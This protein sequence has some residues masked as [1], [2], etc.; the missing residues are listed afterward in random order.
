MTEVII[1]KPQVDE[2]EIWSAIY[3]VYLDFYKMSLTDAQ[4]QK[5]WAWLF[6]QP[7]QI[8]C[9]FAEIKQKVVGLAQF[10][11]FVRPTEACSG[12]FLDD[13]IV[14]PEFRGHGVGYQLIEAVK[15]HAKNN[16]L[17]IVRWITAQDNIQA[18]RLYDSVATKTTWVTYDAKIEPK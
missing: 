15:S 6:E 10:R 3:R 7:Q 2:Y 8:N 1:R 12:V 17:N 13:L 18:M 4:L 14:L 9:Y 5:V 11:S 16:N